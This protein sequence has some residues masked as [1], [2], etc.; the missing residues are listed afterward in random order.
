MSRAGL[1]LLSLTAWIGL[2]GSGW[3]EDLRYPHLERLFQ[4]RDR[5]PDIVRGGRAFWQR[6]EPRAD[7]PARRSSASRNEGRRASAQA[8]ASARAQKN[9]A[10]PAS[11]AA[12]VVPKSFFVAVIGDAMSMML[13]DALTESLA[14]ERPQVEIM[15]KGKDNSGVVREDYYDWRKAAR[16]LANGTERIDYALVMMGAN[17]RQPIREPGGVT[18]E[19]LSEPWREAYGARVGEIVAAFRA[20]NIPV[21]WVGLPVMRSERYGADMQAVNAIARAA[22]E[23]AGGSFVDTWDRFADDSG[24]YEADGPDVNGRVTRLRTA[25][26]IYFTRAG[27]LKL[28]HF[29]ESDVSRLAGAPPV[30]STT[31]NAAPATPL[32]VAPETT[33][34]PPL[35]AGE[36]D[37]AAVI[38][39]DAGAGGVSFGT[40][41]LPGVALP[42]ILPVP[43]FPTRPAAGPVTAL[44]QPPRALDGKL[45]SAPDPTARPAPTEA[46]PGR[47]DDFSW[48]RR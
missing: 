37:V 34:A 46:K 4:S 12:P 10:A 30:A 44:T 40:S 45:A 28:A 35:D 24:A 33:G 41:G 21:V 16:E 47:A 32:A 15:R 23:R 38:R 18:L 13:A 6:E 17:D 29:V 36:I 3:A 9:V 39:R 26:G 14:R 19:T 20:R 2:S 43:V 25:D 1:I 22:A 27:S 8:R 7:A 42:D 11:V 48:P 31:P 5:P